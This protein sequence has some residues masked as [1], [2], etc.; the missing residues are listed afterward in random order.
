MKN[1][2]HCGIQCKFEWLKNL[3]Y[4]SLK[5]SMCN[6]IICFHFKLVS[7]ILKAMV[8]LLSVVVLEMKYGY[9]ID[10]YG[11]AECL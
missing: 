5:V 1:R 6:E 7:F 9:A 4:V 3:K 2:I 11:S 8:E 10:P